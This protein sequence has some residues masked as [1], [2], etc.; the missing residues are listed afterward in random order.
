MSFIVLILAHI[1]VNLHFQDFFLEHRPEKKSETYN[2]NA[3]S[4]LLNL[5]HFFYYKAL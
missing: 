3:L 1:Q 5:H 2:L 4:Q